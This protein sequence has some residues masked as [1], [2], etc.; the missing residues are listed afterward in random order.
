MP[1]SLLVKGLNAQRGT[2]NV[3]SPFVIVILVAVLSLS[4]PSVSQINSLPHGLCS[5]LPFPP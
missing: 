3:F 2:I 5:S 4:R 1:L